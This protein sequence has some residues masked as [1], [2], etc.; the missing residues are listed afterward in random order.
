MRRVLLF[1][2]DLG[3]EQ[4]VKAVL[5]KLETEH[6]IDVHKDP[7]SVTKGRGRMMTELSGFFR[8][9]KGDPAGVPDCVVV[10]TDANCMGL[11]QRQ[12][13]VESAVPADLRGLTVYAIPDPHVERWMLLDSSAFKEVFGAGCDAP[14]QK[15][16]KDRYKSLLGDAIRKAGIRPSLGGMEFATDI[17]KAMDLE[18]V[19]R[20]DP[21]FGRFLDL[22]KAKFRRWAGGSAGL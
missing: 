6:G 17:V 8:D 21:S 1:A 7:R 20:R 14:D 11:N 13:D 9:L 4:F 15:C 5:K 10:A 22:L 19:G 12:R 16:E 3:L 18:D 2:E